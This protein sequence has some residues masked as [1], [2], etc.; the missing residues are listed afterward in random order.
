LNIKKK[1][2]FLQKPQVD[3]RDPNPIT[4]PINLKILLP[5]PD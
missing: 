5:L 2:A 1:I 3:E 4:L